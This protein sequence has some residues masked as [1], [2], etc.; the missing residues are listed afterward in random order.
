[1][2]ALKQSL[3]R[4]GFDIQ[5]LFS[6]GVYNNYLSAKGLS[7]YNLPV[8]ESMCMLV[9]NTKKLWPNFIADSNGQ[10]LDSWTASQI[11]SSA[12]EFVGKFSIYFVFDDYIIHMDKITRGK[13]RIAFQTL[14]QSIGF[15][16]S[17]PGTGLS[18]T[19]EYGPWFAFRAVII[20]HDQKF[21]LPKQ[22]I[23]TLE[24]WI[25]E[26]ISSDQL[27]HFEQ[28][29]RDALALTDA[30]KEFIE[31]RKEIGIL[32]NKQDQEYSY[33]QMMYHY[34]KSKDYLKI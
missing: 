31:I 25:R 20:F 2:L 9:G 26:S 30:F 33:N 27:K 23:Q 19:R 34:T 12:K 7:E 24:D 1:M 6:S 10:S 4:K 5:V 3:S 11:Y 28:K 13:K 17:I 8:T 18:V 32:L 29:T 22:D 14:G 21:E 16:I 15:S